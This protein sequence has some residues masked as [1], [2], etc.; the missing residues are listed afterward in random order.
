MS[1]HDLPGP[2]GRISDVESVESEEERPSRGRKRKI[3][4]SEWKMDWTN[5]LHRCNAPS[6]VSTV[7]LIFSSVSVSVILYYYYVGRE[8]NFLLC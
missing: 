7:L 4:K 2:S 1:D 3:N 5:F 8:G 6:N